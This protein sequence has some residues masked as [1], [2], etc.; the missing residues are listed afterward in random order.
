MRSR[1]I[2]MMKNERKPLTQVKDQF[3]LVIPIA[4]R[5]TFDVMWSS[6]PKT[7]HTGSAAYSDGARAA[8]VK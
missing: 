4:N 6:Q 3:A 1:P 5:A 2:S 8:P 7:D